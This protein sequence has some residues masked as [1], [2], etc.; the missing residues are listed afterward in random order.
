M[1]ALWFPSACTQ[2]FLQDPSRIPEDSLQDSE[3]NSKRFLHGPLK[4]GLFLNNA[5]RISSGGSLGIT[6]RIPK[7][8]INGS[9]RDLHEFP[10][11]FPKDFLGDSLVTL[12]K[13]SLRI[14]LGLP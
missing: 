4:H 12:C 7:R 8:F 5:Q 10:L 14:S 9:P 3:R 2:D 11:G 6:L 1:I 13:D